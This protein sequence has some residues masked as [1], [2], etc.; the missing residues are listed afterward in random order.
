VFWSERVLTPTDIQLVRS[1]GEI[2]MRVRSM[3]HGMAAL[4][5]PLATTAHSLH[6]RAELLSPSAAVK[7]APLR[8]ARTAFWLA[9]DGSVTPLDFPLS[10]PKP[11][12]AQGSDGR[13]WLIAADVDQLGQ[14]VPGSF[15]LYRF[16]PWQK[17]FDAVDFELDFGHLLNQSR[18]VSIGP[19][20]FVWLDG[21]TD[22][23]VFRGV[24]FGTR[25]AFTSDVSLVELTDGTQRPAHLAPDQ[26]PDVN[27]SYTAKPAALRFSAVDSSS[28]PT[29]VWV[30]DAEYGDF[31]A[32]IEFSSDTP[33]TLRLGAQAISDPNSA[34]PSSPCQL[35]VLGAA[36]TIGIERKGAHVTLTIGA[37]NSSCGLDA[38]ILPARV[39]FGVCQSALGPAT[40]TKITVTRGG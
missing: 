7:I 18:L 17:R 14:P 13:P 23:P 40:V 12:L 25:S 1:N 11:I 26:P 27:V 29:C 38:T 2:P 34:H 19:D 39:P 37:A 31:S 3:P 10:A 32:A 8:P 5:S 22:G 4:H 6:C 24:R 9:S 35:P 33:P 28:T 16:D 15:A 21:D 30:A 36:G 20:A